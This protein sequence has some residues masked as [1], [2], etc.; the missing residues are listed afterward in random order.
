MGR[1]V[2]CTAWGEGIGAGVM[3]SRSNGCGGCGVVVVCFGVRGATC[4]A[5][6]T[7]ER[8]SVGRGE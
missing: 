5:V 8:G 4:G 1:Y 2:S 6:Q 7:R 3:S